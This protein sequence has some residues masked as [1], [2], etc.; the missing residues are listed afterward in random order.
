MVMST[1]SHK[2]LARSQ[3]HVS[4]KTVLSSLINIQEH[5]KKIESLRKRWHATSIAEEDFITAFN[6]SE[7]FDMSDVPKQA[8]EYV[9]S[10]Q[11]TRPL[12]KFRKE[13]ARYITKEVC[14][15]PVTCDSYGSEKASSD[16]DVTID[17]HIWHI[18]QGL[19]TYIAI[20]KFLEGIFKGVPFFQ[21]EKGK[22]SLRKVFHFFDI[23]FYLS[24]FAIM[25]HEDLPDNKLSS[26]F[27]STA[28]TTSDQD[29]KNQFYYAFVDI[30]NK[31]NEISGSVED[32]YLNK[33]NTIS[34]M[35]SNGIGTTSE[36]NHLIDLLS[37]ISLYEDECYHTQ[38]AFFH[39]VM[40]IQR[41]KVFDDISENK[42]VFK[43]MMQASA[44]ENL[45]FAYTHFSVEPKRIKYLMRCNDAIKRLEETG[46]YSAQEIV[47]K[48]IAIEKIKTVTPLFKMIRTYIDQFLR[49]E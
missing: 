17:G 2:P 48:P 25:K 22:L 49:K 37:V 29:Y 34:I 28:Y 16:I 42:E 27:L 39:V 4:I 9:N 43:R 45:A 23:N 13:L 40:M 21:D 47:I 5:Q 19:I 1:K 30:V 31:H 35:L 14:K 18:R 7:L 20:T 33:V 32:T 44:L 15:N 24:N 12:Y 46:F 26:Y 6:W 41:K 36:Q 8:Q 10:C 11:R 38:G 3:Q